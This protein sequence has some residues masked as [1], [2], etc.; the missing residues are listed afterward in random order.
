MNTTSLWIQSLVT[1]SR[2]A[3]IMTISHLIKWIERKC[4]EKYNKWRNKIFSM[5]ILVI[6]NHNAF[7]VLFDKIASVY[8]IWKI[9]WYFSTGN[10]Q[11]RKP[12]LCQLYRHTFVPSK[13]KHQRTMN[14]N[15]QT[16]CLR[17]DLLFINSTTFSSLISLLVNSPEFWFSRPVVTLP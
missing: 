15:G 10:G 13:N 12:A 14:C 17:L 7:R 2:K 1:T 3:N 9:Y 16:C 11:P 8:F 5:S 4:A 6:S